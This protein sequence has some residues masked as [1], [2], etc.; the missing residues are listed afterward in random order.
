MGEL[1]AVNPVVH[2]EHLE[3]RLV[4]DQEFLEPVGEHVPVLPLGPVADGYQGL[5]AL[6]LPSDSIIDTSWSP[7]VGGQFV[8]V[9]LG[10]ESGESLGSFLD[11]VDLDQWLDSHL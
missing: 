5:V 7:P 1:S 3:I 9:V 8:G 11:L 4:F 2:E 6:E 10:L